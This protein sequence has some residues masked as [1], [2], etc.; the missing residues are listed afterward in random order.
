MENRKRNIIAVSVALVVPIVLYLFVPKLLDSLNLS[1]NVNRGIQPPHKMYFLK[2]EEATDLVSREKYTDSLYHVV[3][4]YKFQTQNGDS[5]SLDSLRGYMYVANFF[6]ATC[7]GICPKLSN[8]MER[9][10]S[11]FINDVQVKLV[12]ITVDPSRDSLPQLRAYANAHS[13]I[14]GKWYFLRGSQEQVSELA[15]K[16]LYI[17]AKPDDDGI[18]E[19]FVHSEK[20]VL[21][22]KDGNIRNYYSGIDS[23]SVN[24]LM[25]DMI[26]ILRANEKGFSF[27]KQRIKKEQ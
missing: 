14:P 3:P 1:R 6:F 26:L 5:L 10:Q 12:S 9:I 23:L 15:A 11:T 21:I 13:T 4:N 2:A 19:S 25:A 17:T 7:P 8:S 16:G 27:K 18:P 20:L 22:D 24:R